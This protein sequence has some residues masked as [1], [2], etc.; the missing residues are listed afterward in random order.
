[1]LLRILHSSGLTNLS[2]IQVEE[3]ERKRIARTLS[4]GRS[5]DLYIWWLVPITMILVLSTFLQ[6]MGYTELK[7]KFLSAKKELSGKPTSSQHEKINKLESQISELIFHIDILMERVNNYKD[8]YTKESIKNNNIKNDLDTLNNLLGQRTKDLS[9]IYYESKK[10][11]DQYNEILMA[12]AG[13]VKRSF[14]SEGFEFELQRPWIIEE[15]LFL[16]LKIT[17]H[18]KRRSMKLFLNSR[19]YVLSSAPGAII[20]FDNTYISAD[21]LIIREDEIVFNELEFQ[22]GYFFIPSNESLTILY[23]VSNIPKKFEKIKIV[24]FS[25]EIDDS[26]HLKHALLYNIDLN[27]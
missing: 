14:R 18:G 13:S 21:K 12:I 26:E 27:N 1:M 24:K 11:E 4:L 22:G 16:P 20:F 19:N 2:D 8:L 7:L 6:A 23:V 5:Q 10:W 25:Y 15:S 3:Y 17:N 9:K